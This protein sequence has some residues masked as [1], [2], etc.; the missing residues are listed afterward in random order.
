M[1]KLVDHL[2]VFEGEGVIKDYPGNYS[3]FRIQELAEASNR[4][5]KPVAVKV[6]APKT[7]DFTDISTTATKRKLTYKE[8]LEFEQ[9]EK[10]VPAMEK[11]KATL[12]EQIA[13]GNLPYEKLQPLLDEMA[14]LTA[15]LEHKE[16]RWLEL[17]EAIGQV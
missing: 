7:L 6:E 5:K 9:L 8:K 10:E 16:L 3:Q 11:K 14:K 4:N 2:F 13:S 15:D 1:D 17:S 12:N